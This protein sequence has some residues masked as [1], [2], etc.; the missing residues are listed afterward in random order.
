M[1]AAEPASQA[2]VEIWTAAAITKGS[3]GTSL[4]PRSRRRPRQSPMRCSMKQS[5]RTAIA[6]TESDHRD[7]TNHVGRNPFS[8]QAAGDHLDRPGRAILRRLLGLFH[9]LR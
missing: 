7:L 6:I 8:P 4:V 2:S 5:P 3:M 1:Q 9:S